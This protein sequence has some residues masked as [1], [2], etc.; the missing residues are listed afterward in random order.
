M[1]IPIENTQMKLI[2]ENEVY[3]MEEAVANNIRSEA[4]QII[5]L[6][7]ESQDP[8][9]SQFM[10]TSDG[11]TSPPAEVSMGPTSPVAQDNHSVDHLN[12]SQAV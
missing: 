2:R 1:M 8:M 9:S 11:L 5:D 6:H 7:N 10:I 12:M 3:L 4:S